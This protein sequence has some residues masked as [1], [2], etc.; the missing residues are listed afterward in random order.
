MEG[1][2]SADNKIA[3]TDINNDY[4]KLRILSLNVCGLKSKLIIPDFSLL[5][6]KYDILCFLESKTD[7]TDCKPDLIPGYTTYFNNRKGM[8]PSGDII[9]N[10]KYELADIVSLQQK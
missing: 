8:R 1:N 3:N 2:T 9:I 5:I 6:S 10:V 4:T 7:E